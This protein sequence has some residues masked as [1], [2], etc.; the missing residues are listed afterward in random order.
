MMY[1]LQLGGTYIKRL[2][3]LSRLLQTIRINNHQS[4]DNDLGAFYLVSLVQARESIDVL[5]TDRQF[6]MI[7]SHQLSAIENPI[8]G[9]G[10]VRGR[11]RPGSH[12]EGLSR[13]RAC[14]ELG[15]N[16]KETHSRAPGGPENIAVLKTVTDL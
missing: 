13:R 7:R 2:T 6:R 11:K 16:A 1:R 5:S 10:V 4:R 8:H 12:V 3:H 14:P 9:L 15:H